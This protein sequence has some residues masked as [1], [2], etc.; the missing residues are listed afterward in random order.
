VATVFFI[1][2]VTSSPG[3]REVQQVREVADRLIEQGKQAGILAP[4][5][6]TPP[7]Q[8]VVLPRN[9]SEI[10]IG[11][12]NI[13]TFGVAKI[14]NQEVMSTL[15]K[16]A[17]QFDCLAIQEVRSKH[18]QTILQ[19]YIDMINA[20]GS[21]YDYVL[22]PLLGNS[23]QTFQYGILYDTNRIE[24]TDS[25]FVVPDPNNLMHREPMVS[26]F[27]TR[28]SV[29]E[30]AFTF[31]LVDVHIDPNVTRAELDVLYQVYQWLRAYM[32][33]EDDI[34]VLGDFNEPPHRYGNMW[35]ITTLR[36]AIADGITTNTLRNAAYDNILFD[37]ELTREYTGRSG[38]LDVEKAFGLTLEQTQAVSDHLP[39]W[40]A[41][42]AGEMPR[43]QYA[44]QP[45]TIGR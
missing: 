39:V 22:S 7:V 13:Q 40:A 4:K 1:A 25:G 19:Q 27:R 11:T 14:R 32:P 44:N 23:Y 12:M 36:A 45:G 26:R 33:D 42:T 15:V 38:V 41:F 6:G 43:P 9:P 8:Q 30:Q 35:Q 3:C 37:G 10:I 18:D 31:A 17:R 16:I 20:D 21:R 34:I 5:T 29:P 28:T 24:L 2:L